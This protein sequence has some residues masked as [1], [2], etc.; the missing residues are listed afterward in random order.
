M[1][2]FVNDECLQNNQ[3]KSLYDLMSFK[4]FEQAKGIA[5]AVNNHVI[6]KKKWEEHALDDGDKILIIKAAAGG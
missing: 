5:V 4:G 3:W 2:L 6:P 1:Q